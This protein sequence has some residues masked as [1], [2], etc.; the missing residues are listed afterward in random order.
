M[1]ILKNYLNYGNF[2][3]ASR[4][5]LHLA[6]ASSQIHRYVV[7]GELAFLMVTNLVFTDLLI[8]GIQHNE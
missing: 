2:T 6:R 8:L 5:V 3:I 1:E 7:F 4:S